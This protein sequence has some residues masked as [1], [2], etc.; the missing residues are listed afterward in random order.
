MNQPA[1]S[2]DRIRD[3]VAGVLLVLLLE[4]GVL[5][6]VGYA[7]GDPC[8]AG[9]TSSTGTPS[10]TT[11]DPGRAFVDGGAHVFKVLGSQQGGSMLGSQ[12]GGSIM[13]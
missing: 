7:V 10:N 1:T 13:C 8:P 5:V 2:K 6:G 3:F 4:I 9:E 11:K 12:Q